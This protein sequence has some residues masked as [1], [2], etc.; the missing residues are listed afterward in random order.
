VAGLLQVLLTTVWR[1]WRQDHPLQYP[2]STQ[3]PHEVPQEVP[4]E[5]ASVA[6]VA[7]VV[8]VALS[9][10]PSANLL[11]TAPPGN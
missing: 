11:T 4:E 2:P 7:P 1:G 8:P 10:P 3:S 9:T 5:D 6:P